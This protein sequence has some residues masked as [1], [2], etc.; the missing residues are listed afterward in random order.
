MYKWEEITGEEFS[1]LFDVCDY[2]YSSADGDT[3]FYKVDTPHNE[4]I[5]IGAIKEI[6]KVNHYYLLIRDVEEV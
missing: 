3:D 5:F 6:E 4:K 2:Q 1:A